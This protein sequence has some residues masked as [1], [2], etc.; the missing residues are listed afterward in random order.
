MI[1]YSRTYVELTDENNGTVN[2][3]ASHDS[4]C[5]NS[6]PYAQRS[7]KGCEYVKFERQPK[8]PLA[9]IGIHGSVKCD[10]HKCRQSTNDQRPPTNSPGVLTRNCLNGHLGVGC[11]VIRPSVS[12]V[13]LNVTV[14]LFYTWITPLFPSNYFI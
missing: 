4:V 3:Q 13:D 8:T 1:K 12:V 9:P 11:Q 2:R 6:E 5:V 14:P 7:P 10:S